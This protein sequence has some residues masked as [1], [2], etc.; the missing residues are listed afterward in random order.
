MLA[1]LLNSQ[2]RVVKMVESVSKRMTN[3]ESTVTG[4][5]SKL[6]ENNSLPSSSSDRDERRRLPQQ[7]SVS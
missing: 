7:L 2:N 1:T 6:T 3:L 5:T 4:L